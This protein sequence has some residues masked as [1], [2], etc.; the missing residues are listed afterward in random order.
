MAT[1]PLQQGQQCY[2]IDGKDAWTAKMP[3]H[4][5]RQHHCD[6]GNHASSMTAKMPAH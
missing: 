4:Q 6:K 2:H 5:Q 3:A 1:T